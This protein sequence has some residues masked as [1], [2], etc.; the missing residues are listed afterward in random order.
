MKTEALVF[1]SFL[2]VSFFIGALAA[3][4]INSISDFFV[5][6]AKMPWYFLTGTFVASNVSA[7]LFLG[8]TNMAGNH[9]YAV[10]S[11]FFTTAI[12]YLISIA[13]VGV[14]VRRLSKHYKVYDFAD[15]L[16]T[17][18]V[19]HAAV[20]R[21]ITT[22]VLPVV[23]IP[24]LAAQFIALASITE[25]IFGINYE[26]AL[27][28]ISLLIIAYTVLGGMLGVVWTDG[29][30]FL[31]L[32]FGLLLAV[33]I[34]MSH[35]GEGSM[36]LGWQ[37]VKALPPEIFHWTNQ[38]WPWQVVMGQFAWVFAAPVMP[39]LITRF[40]TA[41]DERQILIALPVSLTLGMVIF[42]SVIP[43][44]LLGRVA[45]PN[46]AQGE[47]YYLALA[48][49]H[50]GPF[51]GS[52]ALS[53]IAAAA[54]STCST[55]LMITGQSISKEIYQKIFSPQASDE[56]MLFAARVT[57]TVIG[58]ITFAIAY[59]KLLSIFWLVVLSASLLASIFFIPVMAGFFSEKASAKGAIAAALG[60]GG[61]ALI[62]FAVNERLDTY[63]FISELFAGLMASA[64]CMLV[65]SYKYPS[66]S[67][68]RAVYF[69]IRS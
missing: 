58:I 69:R 47:Y 42:A 62:I 48:S 55:C 61:S 2:F 37:N 19:S 14:F 5:A 46:L 41:K 15:I 68:E 17:R 25:S 56:H 6:G 8:A 16:A 18:Y 13:I 51:V 53:G 35:A 32:L 21:M 3:R 1:S 12:G 44:G 59:I 11:S 57:I 66:T 4:S 39:H 49:S 31:V 34:A 64:I 24:L 40:L 7:G 20:I 67:E 54:L 29:F 33:P 36:D 45:Y 63:Y 60:G 9:G 23:Y 10:Y 38:G 27:L 50:L 26:T 28:A 43:L 22:L 52:F 65:F 30:Q